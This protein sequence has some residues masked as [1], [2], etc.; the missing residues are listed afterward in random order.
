MIFGGFEYDVQAEAAASAGERAVRGFMVAV[1]RATSYVAS[2]QQVRFHHSRM[3]TTIFRCMFKALC[4]SHVLTYNYRP[5]YR[6]FLCINHVLTY[7]CFLWQYLA[8][9]IS[10]LL[11][12]VDGAHAACCEQMATAMANS[13]RAA[14]KGLQMCI[15]TI[16]AEVSLRFSTLNFH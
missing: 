1:C 5:T 8:N 3:K 9:N 16:M 10:R 13:E 2:V 6:C 15:D 4:I 14:L 12:P 11:L 7:R